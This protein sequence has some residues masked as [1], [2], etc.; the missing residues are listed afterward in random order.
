MKATIEGGE[1]AT[2]KGTAFFYKSSS[3]PVSGYISGYNNA[4]SYGSF[5]P[6]E[7]QNFFDSTFGTGAAGSST[8][9]N[10]ELTMKKGSRLFISPNVKAKISQLV[11]GDLFSGIIG[12][13]GISSNSSDDYTRNLLL[14]SELEIDR[15]VDL[16]LATETYNNLEISN[17]SIINN[18]IIKGTKDRQY[19]MVQENYEANRGYVTLLNNQNKE[20][21][22]SGNEALGM[23]AKNAYILNKGEITLNGNKATAIYGMD[24]TL[25]S[26]T[27]T[28][29]IKLN[30]DNS[31]GIFYD[32]TDIS[33]IGE[34]I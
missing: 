3:V 26:N 15:P 13:P 16:D 21:N 9:N 30:G 29:K 28:S 1:S 19:A 17:S 33:S 12:A 25:I 8:L 31:I 2:E 7:V 6:G 5:T 24:N 18:N 10:L 20:I 27:N 22:L 23:Y 11:V 34:N 14:K 4:I 32:N